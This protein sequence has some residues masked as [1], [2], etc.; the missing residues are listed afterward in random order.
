MFRRMLIA[1]RGEIAIRIIHA[2]RELGIETVAVF[3][4]ADARAA[5]VAMAD[6]TVRI[7]PPPSVESYLSIERIIDAAT[8]TGCD[9]VHPGYGFLSENAAFALACQQAGLVFVGPPSDVIA[10]MGSKTEARR[11]MLEAGVPI[12]PGEHP[13]DQ[14]DASI[15][16]AANR[17]GL[18]VLIKAVAGGGGKGMRL[19]RD[20]RELSEGIDAARR[21][22]AAAFG[23]ATLYIERFIER[24]RHVE[25]QAMAD[26][27]GHL[28][29]LFER[30]CSVQRRHQKV[31]EESPSPLLTHELRAQMTAAAVAGAA[32][33]GYRNAGTLEFLVDGNGRDF[34]FLEMNTRLQVEHGVTEAVVG[35]DLVHAQIAV[36]AGGAL[37]W[38]QTGL[39]QRGHAIECRVYAE[40]PADHF[41]PQTGRALVYRPPVIPG[42]RIDAG[43]REGDEIPVFYDPLIAKLIAWGETRPQAI[44]RAI[45]ALRGFP[46]LGL[47]TNVSFLI[48]VLEHPAFT[49]GDVYTSFVE[50]HV[51]ELAVNP[52]LT[53]QAAAVA[54]IGEEPERLAGT[55]R[56]RDDLRTRADRDPWIDL[57]NWRG[58]A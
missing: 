54:A 29:H 5:H 14:S 46:I 8:S 36:A 18:P 43:F 7:G 26:S 13:S 2:C 45:A 40:D 50:E 30:E 56:S 41:L 27:Q 53:A 48:R 32:G 6:R 21:E 55:A 51:D 57:K 49:S 1:N 38:T 15:T 47:R 31:I 4:D 33:A 11:V 19:A 17:V 24:P 42:V 58:Q 35:V 16:A 20:R 9:V 39:H 22:A 3:S 25:I 28:V 10:R 12:V 44:H 37:P 34:Y 23:D 52:P